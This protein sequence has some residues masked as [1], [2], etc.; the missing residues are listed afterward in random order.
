MFCAHSGMMQNG[1]N[2]TFCHLDFWAAK[3]KLEIRPFTG[4]KLGTGAI[5]IQCWEHLCVTTWIFPGLWVSTFGKHSLIV[6]FLDV[7]LTLMR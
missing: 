6:S 4:V 2:K 7:M 1:P 5:H 3:D